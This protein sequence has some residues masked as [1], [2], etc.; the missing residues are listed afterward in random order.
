MFDIECA[1]CTIDAHVN[2]DLACC[3]DD[4]DAPWQCDWKVKGICTSRM[5]ERIDLI[6]RFDNNDSLLIRPQFIRNLSKQ[7]IEEPCILCCF[8]WK[9]GMIKLI[10]ND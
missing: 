2:W 10:S 5:T 6:E 3:D 8:R 4:V 7:A 1:Q 9:G